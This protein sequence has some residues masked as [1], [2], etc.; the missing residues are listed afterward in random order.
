MI[1]QTFMTIGAIICTVVVGKYI[2]KE[3]GCVKNVFKDI[4][5]ELKINNEK[6]GKFYHRAQIHD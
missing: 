6:K 5:N 3:K 1:I 4:R 2:W